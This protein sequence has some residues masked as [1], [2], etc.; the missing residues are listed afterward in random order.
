MSWQEKLL[1]K[2][3]HIFGDNFYF[4][5]EG[6]WFSVIDKM[7][8]QITE[9]LQ[10]NPSVEKVTALQ[11]KEKFGTMRF[12]YFGGDEFIEFIVSEAEIN[13]G[14]TCELSGGDGELHRDDGGYLK[15]LSKFA[16]QLTNFKPIKK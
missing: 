6:G 3:P 4:E 14:E 7:C 10:K 5:C 8:F 16:G 2:Y 9:Y 13:S 11:L 12:Y 15:T 1:K